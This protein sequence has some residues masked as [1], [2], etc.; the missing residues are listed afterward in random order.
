ME[1]GVKWVWTAWEPASAKFLERKDGS[2]ELMWMGGDPWKCG[3]CT[4]DT[5]TT[6]EKNIHPNPEA[7]AGAG[8]GLA[9]HCVCSK[10]RWWLL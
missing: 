10:R 3:R 4:P 7:R 2:D 6:T 9:A 1:N 5:E 8:A